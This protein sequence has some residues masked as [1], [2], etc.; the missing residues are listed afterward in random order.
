M[1]VTDAS[2]IVETGATAREP[3]TA[4]DSLRDIFRTPDAKIRADPVP[5]HGQLGRTR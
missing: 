1:S 3:S 2:I 4:C 5:H